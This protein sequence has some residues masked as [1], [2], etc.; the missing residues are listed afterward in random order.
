MLKT[1]LC[2]AFP[3]A[4]LTLFVYC[5]STVSAR[6]GTQTVPNI[7]IEIKLGPE[8]VVFVT[9][10]DAADAF[11]IPDHSARAFRDKNGQTQLLVGHHDLYR[12]IGPDLNRVKRDKSKPVW[13]SHQNSDLKMHDNLE[14]IAATYTEDG[15]T[16]HALV[17]NEYHG[18]RVGNSKCETDPE[19]NCWYNSITYAVSRDGGQ[20]YTHPEPPNH[21]VL[22]PYID[23]DPARCKGPYGY[24]EPSNIIR[25]D[26]FYY[27][28]LQMETHEQQS[29]GTGLIRTKNLANPK[30]WTAWDGAKFVPIDAKTG[31][32]TRPLKPIGEGRLGKLH[33]SVTWN[34]YLHA[35][36]MVGLHEQD[37]KQGVFYTLS[38]DLINWSD[39]RVLLE[40]ILPWRAKG[41]D[42]AVAYPSLLQPEDKSRNYERT[43]RDPYLYYITWQSNVDSTKRKI[44]RR[45]VTFTGIAKS[46]T[47][48]SDSR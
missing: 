45:K 10:T 32:A 23:Y 7:D 40:V 1:P 37:G 18:N 4:I 12:S 30:S 43:K 19:F 17:H 21:L 24:F 48:K 36:I 25:K 31:K 22:A 13:K 5:G 34:E 33:H 35:Y 6:C 26:G 2:F 20:T 39:P 41:P 27:V 46:V 14:W 11:D 47:G 9:E 42:W 29:W 16:I 38:N 3:A 44:I 15:R 28:F 8:E